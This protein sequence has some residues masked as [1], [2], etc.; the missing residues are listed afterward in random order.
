M[1]MKAGKKLKEIKEKAFAHNKLIY[2]VENCG[3][4]DEKVYSDSQSIP[5]EAGY[6]SLVIV[7]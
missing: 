1:I 2:L 6:F 3:M 4:P 7:K 5:D